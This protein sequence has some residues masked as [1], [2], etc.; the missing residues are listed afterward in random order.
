MFMCFELLIAVQVCL[1]LNSEAITHFLRVL[2]A[3]EFYSNPEKLVSHKT[4]LQDY[5]VLFKKKL[6]LQSP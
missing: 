4:F 3:I 2:S 1:L 6:H 5:G